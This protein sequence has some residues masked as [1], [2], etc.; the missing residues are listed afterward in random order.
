MTLVFFG[1]KEARELYFFKGKAAAFIH[2][3]RGKEDS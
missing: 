1:V 3:K 2:G